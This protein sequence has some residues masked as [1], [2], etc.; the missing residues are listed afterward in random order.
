MKENTENTESMDC[1]FFVFSSD[2][3]K[4]DL[5]FWQEKRSVKQ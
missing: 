1:F 3:V 2:T 4:F 5:L